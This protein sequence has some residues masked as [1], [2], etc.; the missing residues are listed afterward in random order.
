MKD[1]VCKHCGT[2][3]EYYTIEKG[4]HKMAFCNHCK[5]WITN[6]GYDDPLRIYFGKYK[7]MTIKEIYVADI[8]Y[9]RWLYKQ[10][11]EG[12]MKLKKE[13]I[14]EIVRLLST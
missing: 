10:T 12:D 5:K 11:Q 2:I 13:Q 4:I 7:C 8:G 3:N 14:D 1:V 9:I 6:I